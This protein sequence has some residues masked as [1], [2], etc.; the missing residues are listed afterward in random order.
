MT[1]EKTMR[2]YRRRMGRKMGWG[3]YEESEEEC[4]QRGR[5][6]KE[7]LVEDFPEVKEITP[8]PL[9]SEET[10]VLTIAEYEAMRLVDQEGLNQAEA[11][12]L[13]NVSRGTIW[14]LLDSGRAKML[15]VLTEGKRLIMEQRSE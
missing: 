4:R 7:V 8:E 5:P 10:V 6:P 12:E 2:N 1:E 9:L 15:S 14:R 13:M 11:G 3:R